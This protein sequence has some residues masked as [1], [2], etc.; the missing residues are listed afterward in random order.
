MGFSN[1]YLTEDEKKLIA[2]TRHN[3][4]TSIDE[5]SVFCLK[6]KVTVD[7]NR[8]IWF[9]SNTKTREWDFRDRG[10]LFIMFWGKIHKDNVIEITLK[11]MG[12]E[13]IDVTKVKDGIEVIRYWGIHSIKMSNKLDIDKCAIEDVLGEI[14]TAYGICGDPKHKGPKYDGKMKVIIKM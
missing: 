12:R 5:T 4:L 3:K 2:E 11:D 8:K 14:M 6:E 10:Y 9:L 7:R 1:E 13:Y